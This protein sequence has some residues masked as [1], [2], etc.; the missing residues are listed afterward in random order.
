VPDKFS[1]IYWAH[2]YVCCF[3]LELN[4]TNSLQ[5]LFRR[6]SIKVIIIIG[7]HVKPQ[8]FTNGLTFRIA[9][10]QGLQRKFK[11]KQL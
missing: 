8:Q 7:G 2:F 4:K 3:T 9:E 11:L 10:T 6:L 5:E 1:L